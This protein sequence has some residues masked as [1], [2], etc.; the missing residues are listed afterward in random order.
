ML[1]EIKNKIWYRDNNDGK[2]YNCCKVGDDK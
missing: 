1:E 2:F